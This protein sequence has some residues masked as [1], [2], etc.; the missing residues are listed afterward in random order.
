MLPPTAAG[1]HRVGRAQPLTTLAEPAVPG[2]ATY[3]QRH[4]EPFPIPDLTPAPAAPS[5]LRRL[6]RSLI[7][8]SSSAP[9]AERERRDPPVIPTYWGPLLET[10]RRQ[11]S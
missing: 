7:R 6:A 5:R 1:A 8:R 9:R 10:H 11:N 2:P 4:Q 3:P